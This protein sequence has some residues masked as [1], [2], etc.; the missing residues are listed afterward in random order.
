MIRKPPSALLEEGGLVRTLD[1][2]RSVADRGRTA[3]RAGSFY[4]RGLF[5][6]GFALLWGFAA[7]GAGL[8]G[9]VGSF[10]GIGLMAA[11]VAWMGRRMFAK[12][13]GLGRSPGFVMR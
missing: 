5:C 4:L 7:L 13:Q 8:C 12:A 2:A 3:A 10:L 1:R 11:G 6:W 9:D